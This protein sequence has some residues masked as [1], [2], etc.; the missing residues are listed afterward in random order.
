MTP[1]E[2]QEMINRITRAESCPWDNRQEPFRV[3]GNIYYVGNR[4]VGYYLI[5]GEDRTAL[6]DCGP[7][8]YI[9]QLVDSLWRIGVRPEEVTDLLI[10][11]GHFDHCGGA[12]EFMDL[13]GCRCHF[14]EGDAFFLTERRDL[15]VHEEQVAP[16]HVDAYYD[17]D[18]TLTFGGTTV[19]PVH[20]PGHTPGTTSFLITTV[21]QGREVTCALMGG[22]G[23][24]GLEKYELRQNGLPETLQEDFHQALLALNKWKVDVT[25]PSHP[26]VYPEFLGFVGKG[27]RAFINQERWQKMLAP[28]LAGIERMIRENREG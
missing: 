17:Y 25:L 9:Y 10:T 7:R 6:I 22:L 13:T 21:E 27:P 23:L 18:G 12:K 15:I 5:K 2:K 3:I 11:H 4:W 24:N 20:T 1:E 8:G 16:F 26:H 28:K 19:K 14:P